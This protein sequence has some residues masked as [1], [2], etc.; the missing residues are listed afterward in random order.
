MQA[1]QEA[2]RKAWWEPLATKTK[3]AYKTVYKKWLQWLAAKRIAEPEGEWSGL[4]HP[5]LK[6]SRF[7]K[8]E[9]ALSKELGH[10]TV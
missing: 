7:A 3:A 8:D 10:N 9:N 5:P 2:A 4:A 6:V 1:A